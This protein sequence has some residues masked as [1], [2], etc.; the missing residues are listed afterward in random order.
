MGL[1][2]A[3]GFGMP[4]LQAGLIFETRGFLLLLAVTEQFQNISRLLLVAEHA[5]S[6]PALLVPV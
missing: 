5:G 1:F 2:G 3:L 6:E 4:R